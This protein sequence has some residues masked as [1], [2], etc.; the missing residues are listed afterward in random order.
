MST[1]SS[2]SLA[3]VVNTPCL[4]VFG[5]TAT[6]TPNGGTSVSVALVWE[7]EH[8]EV[9]LED[10]DTPV[11]AKRP[12]FWGRDALFAATPKQDDGISYRGVTYIVTEVQPE[13]SGGLYLYVRIAA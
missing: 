5:D 8:E 6:F 13:E 10:N 7:S 3:D 9:V 12:R 4:D 11:L 1:G 2:W